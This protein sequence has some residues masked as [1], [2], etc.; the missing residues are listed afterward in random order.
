MG[1][2]KRITALKT[3]AARRDVPVPCELVDAIDAFLEEYPPAVDGR[4]IHGANGE[5]SRRRA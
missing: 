5:W 1:R 2:E 3:D 4:I